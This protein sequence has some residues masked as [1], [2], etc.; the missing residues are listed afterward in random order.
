MKWC[1]VA[2]FILY[3]HIFLKMGL[4]LDVNSFTWGISLAGPLILVKN[5]KILCSMSLL[6]KEICCVFMAIKY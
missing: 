5:A 3:P 2:L 1:Y 6:K 4:K